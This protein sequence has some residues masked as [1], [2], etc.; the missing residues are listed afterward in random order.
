MA[1]DRVQLKQE[2]VVGNELILN[3]INPKSNTKSI[4]DPATGAT[5]E[6]VIERIWNAINN[7]LSRIV[8]SVNGMTGVVVIDSATIGLG[9]VDNV[10]FAEIKE[11]V[12]S[13]I[14]QEMGYKR[15]EMFESLQELDETINTVWNNDEVYS[16]KPFYARHGYQN[17]KRGYIGYIYYDNGALHHAQK[18][19]DTVGSADNTIIYN[20]NVN[21]RQYAESGRIGVNI[22]KYED[23][24]KVY[25]DLSDNKAESGLY[26]DKSKVKAT[27]YWFDGVYG[28]GD[29]AD[30]GALLYY[31]GAMPADVH[32]VTFRID[33]RP[34][35]YPAPDTQFGGTNFIKQ[36]FEKGDIIICN[37]NDELYLESPTG[38]ANCRTLP[39]G[40]NPMLMVR[41]P[42]IGMVTQAPTLDNPDADYII[43]FYTM[44]QSLF[45]GLK[46]EPIH[47][48]GNDVASEALTVDLLETN[49]LE[50]GDQTP[51]WTG[52]NV[53]ISGL[54]AFYPYDKYSIHQ[55]R[56]DVPKRSFK[57]ILPTG[58]SGDI[59]RT[60]SDGTCNEK[61]SM[62]VLPNYSL[63]VIPQKVYNDANEL[64][65]RNWPP[66]FAGGQ[67]EPN[68][69]DHS[70]Y[71][72]RHENQSVLGINLVKGIFT[73][74]VDRKYAVNMS[75][76][77]IND[78]TSD[79][80]TEWFGNNTTPTVSTHSGG[81]SVN[82]GQFLEIGSSD[83]TYTKEQSRS[84]YYYEGKVNVRI[85]KMLGLYEVPSSN[86]FLRTNRLGINIA[87]GSI[88]EQSESTVDWNDGGLYFVDGGTIKPNHGLLA[89]NTA[90][91][92]SGL[93]VFNSY[94]NK[95]IYNGGDSGSSTSC[96]NVL[97]IRI[98]ELS[99]P[100]KVYSDMVQAKDN[101]LSIQ[102][103][104][105]ADI[106]A[107]NMDIPNIYKPKQW[108]SYSALRNDYAADP[109]A[110][111][112]DHVYIA[113]GA[114]Y[115]FSSHLE[116][117]GFTKYFA[118]YDDPDEYEQVLDNMRDG[119]DLVSR[120][121]AVALITRKDSFAS[122]SYSIKISKYFES[123]LDRRIPDVNND[124]IIDGT[125]ATA[126]LTL[127][128]KSKQRIYN[129][130][131]QY[132]TDE[133]HT[134]VLVPEDGALY[135]IAN[136]TIPGTTIRPI[137]EGYNGSLR[138]PQFLGF[139]LTDTLYAR[140]DA[141]RNG[142]VDASDASLTLTFYAEAS[143][144]EF[145][146][147]TVEEAWF[148]YLMKKRGIYV[149]LDGDPIAEICK[150]NF[151]PGLRANVN[152][153][154]GLTV[155]TEYVDNDP[156]KI[157]LM[158]NNDEL[159]QLAIKI[160][161]TTAGFACEDTSKNG[162]LRFNSGG[163]LGIRINGLNNFSAVE[164]NKINGYDSAKV[165]SHGLRIFDGNILGIQLKGELKDNG[166]LCID[167]D[168]NLKISPNFVPLKHKLTFKGYFNN[169]PN[170]T[171]DFDG[172][173]D[174]TI[175]LGP[176]LC[177]T[178]EIM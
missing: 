19:L 36:S 103:E 112:E 163:Y 131:G 101:C 2:E 122:T 154:K 115:I 160:A 8:N 125:D 13:R 18:A 52:D 59:F 166:D 16:N 6:K 82:V 71:P 74:A 129:Y 89:V 73:N 42:A 157:Q 12:I 173:E 45:R 139:E 164:R 128:S 97:G 53:P 130:E 28:S 96:S 62:F 177:F 68:P 38:T 72:D 40:M 14:M 81:L 140:A 156:M 108:S 169:V 91:G 168:G 43:D 107:E 165:G 66:A 65:I 102:N 54:N 64:I 146:G 41:K 84:N 98:Y 121:R 55:V 58:L 29:P 87:D 152:E 148:T 142:V 57:T 3:D 70:P 117:P 50:Y 161:D 24:L 31:S 90:R 99:D 149:S 120:Q 176:G 114:Y 155:K 32:E 22:W 15:I 137:R 5:L 85:D 123:S 104:I 100:K 127:Y 21:D 151:E 133:E 47:L 126:I 159:Y 23:A 11:W 150:F 80:T 153:L 39:L 4:D 61:G 37:F 124:G 30:S 1:E 170:H 83:D 145:P 56:N 135:Y 141:D 25:N 134:Q 178:E 49:K 138:Y 76:L 105:R 46:Y 75:G 132:Y 136:E 143:V 144:G 118:I 33:H 162:G 92:F 79:L 10:S 110:F 147:L 106:L 34:I 116:T 172:S 78:D 69:V 63:C 77:R 86:V 174:T 119:T 167:G 171:F 158:A 20:E 17:D 60:D 26:I 94:E 44:R 48:T 7:K 67:T 111:D 35:V 93:K 113:G 9:N 109:S 95:Y 88:Y 27:L 175:E 51:M